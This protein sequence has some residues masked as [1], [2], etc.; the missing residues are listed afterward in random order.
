MTTV[1]SE[2]TGGE[3]GSGAAGCTGGGKGSEPE[4]TESLKTF[5]AVV[6]AFRARA[7]LTQEEFAPQ[8]QYSVQTVASIEQGRRFPPD[9]FVER[10]EEVLDAF[11]A[12]RGAAKHLTRRPGLASWFRRW[13]S[14]EEEAVSLC[15]YECRVVPGLLQTEAYARAVTL[16]VPPPPSDEQVEQRVAARLERQRLLK[17]VPLI[18]ISFIIDQAVI[19]RRTGGR[20]VTGELIDH[21][22]NCASLTNVELQVMPL[23]QHDHAGL[24]GPILLL[25]TEGARWLGYSEGQ[26]SGGLISDPQH[27]SILLQRYAKMRSQALTPVD[28]VSL[29]K[30]IQG[31]L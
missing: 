21:L 6:K 18:A 7:R 5:G 22:L 31:A 8:V 23:Q 10:A 17:R 3:G 2:G 29:L 9:N 27:V 13:A 12:L 26:Q 14:L 25:E 16:S 11:G 30:R 4:P 24:D 20:E 1:A 28:S 19:E 15:T